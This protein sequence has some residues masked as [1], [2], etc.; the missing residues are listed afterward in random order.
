MHALPVFHAL[1]DTQPDAEIAWA[2]QPEF[3]GLLAG[4]PGLGRIFRF[5][6]RGG[7]R[8]WISLL[9]GIRAW[10]PDWAVD[11]QGNAKS[12]LVTI[13]SGA[14]RRSGLHPRDWRER[15]AACV[16][17]DHAPALEGPLVHAMQRMHALARHVA[18]GSRSGN[19][20]RRDP[21]LSQAE[22][23]SGHARLDGLVGSQSAPIAILH[24]SSPRDVR[25]WP[26]R[27]FE[28]LARSLAGRGC[29]VLV[30]SGP[31]ESVEGRGV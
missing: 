10:A 15:F 4:L 12:A 18:S 17:T 25:S 28:S 24:L 23:D 13:G 27:S 5:E 22:L 9:S 29:Q 26:I 20:E 11:A 19:P 14:R 30:L 1:R 31:E 2:V 6:R 8:A 21:G 7:T 16:L 3:A